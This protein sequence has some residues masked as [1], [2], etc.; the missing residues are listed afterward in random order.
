ME[1]MKQGTKASSRPARCILVVTTV[2]LAI[3]NLCKTGTDLDSVAW[4]YISVPGPTTWSQPGV[5]PTD[6]M[7]RRQGPG[8]VLAAREAGTC[9]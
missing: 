1:P 9:S 6:I 2:Q 7:A 5:E 4:A 8:K 3:M